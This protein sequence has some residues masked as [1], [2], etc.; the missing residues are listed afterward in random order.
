MVGSAGRLYVPQKNHIVVLNNDGSYLTQWG[1]FGSGDGQFDGATHVALDAR[2]SI[3]VT[4]GFNHRIQK[5]GQ[6]PTPAKASS[7]ARVKA[8]YRQAASRRG[9]GPAARE[10][11][12]GTT[13]V[14]RRP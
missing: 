6:L 11:R 3:Y 13:K 10:K 8:L 12:R 1:S 2:G 5:F 14:L 4:D 7:W 9:A